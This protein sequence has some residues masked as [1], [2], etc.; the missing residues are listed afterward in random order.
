MST[1]V[2]MELQKQLGIKT[3]IRRVDLD[4]HVELIKVL[5]NF[6]EAR[7]HEKCKLSILTMKAGTH[8][9]V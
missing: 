5:I 9:L 3:Y 6:L 2:T 7:D 4:R 8:I 1:L